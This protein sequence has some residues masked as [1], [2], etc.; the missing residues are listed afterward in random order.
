MAWVTHSKLRSTQN[1]KTNVQDET[2]LKWNTKRQLTVDLWQSSWENKEH[3][4][5]LTLKNKMVAVG[6]TFFNIKKMY[7][8][9]LLI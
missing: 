1:S 2:N 6:A 7:K 9:Y 3:G 4:C 8:V 5:Q